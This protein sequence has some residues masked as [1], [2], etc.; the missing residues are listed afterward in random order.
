MDFTSNN[1]A[2]TQDTVV[3]EKKYS[4]VLMLLCFYLFLIIERPWESIS[5]LHNIPIER[6]FAVLLLLVAFLS[7]K[8]HLRGVA[9]DKW[10]LTLLG[11]HFILAPFSYLPSAGFDQG[12]EYAKMVVVYVLILSCCEDEADLRLI[13]KVFVLSMF[14]YVL[15]S[16]WEYTNGRYVYRM[17]ISRMI[18]VDVLANDPNSFA[19]SM[20]LSMPLVWVVYKTEIN[21]WFRRLY[22]GYVLLALVCIV[23]TGSRSG[24]LAL[25]F[26]IGLVILCQKGAR[27]LKL[28]AVLILSILLVWAGMPEEKKERM[29]TVWDENAGP[30]NAHE[31]TEGRSKGFHAGWEMFKERPLT[32]IGVGSMNFITYRVEHGDG[33]AEQAHNTLGE[34]LGEFG[35][36]GLS[37]FIGLVASIVKLFRSVLAAKRRETKG[38]LFIYDLACAG[39]I[40]V[41]LLLFLG[42]GGHNFYRPLWLWLAAWASLAAFFSS[43]D[44]SGPGT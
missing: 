30:T 4:R 26:L 19:A 15:H 42:V 13:I 24:T 2:L 7:G 29:R 12:I 10:V 35:A 14:I 3:D 43:P 21:K 34:I 38:P 25:L 36:M 37:L 18:G 27:R 23:L 39:I 44:V 6:I 33:I 41:L 22:I 1:S 16:F 17:G 40:T 32:G 20:V 28:A 9:T 31:S 5:Y 11:I 8:L